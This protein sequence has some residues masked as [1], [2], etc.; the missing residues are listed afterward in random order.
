VLEIPT[1]SY[2]FARPHRAGAPP[3]FGDAA[4]QLL[5]S[6]IAILVVLAALAAPVLLI[7]WRLHV[8]YH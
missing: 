5:P 8:A 3:A 2:G 6:L 4:K 1:T 7:L